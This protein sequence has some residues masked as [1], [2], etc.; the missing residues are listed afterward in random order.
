[1]PACVFPI[2]WWFMVEVWFVHN[3]LSCNK[4]WLFRYF[5]HRVWFGVHDRFSVWVLKPWGPNEFELFSFIVS[6][7]CCDDLYAFCNQIRASFLDVVLCFGWF[8]EFIYFIWY[9]YVVDIHVWF[10]PPLP[11]LSLWFYPVL[12]FLFPVDGVFFPLSSFFGFPFPSSFST[13]STSVEFSWSNFCWWSGSLSSFLP[14]WV[15][16]LQFSSL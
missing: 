14:V 15:V 4:G 12:I 7:W 6:L 3:L 1:M 13:C 5:G 2:F 16:V 9:W 11:Y 8:I 10:L